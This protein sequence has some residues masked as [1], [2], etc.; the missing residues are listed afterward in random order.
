MGVP[1][2]SPLSSLASYIFIL[3]YFIYLFFLLNMYWIYSN[4]A[5]SR[6]NESC[7]SPCN[8]DIK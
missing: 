5:L 4:L 1:S 3:F 8:V 7:T 6:L 2:L